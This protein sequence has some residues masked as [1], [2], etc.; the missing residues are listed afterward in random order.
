MSI[1]VL[2]IVAYLTFF[3]LFGLYLNRSNKSSSDWATGGGTMGI[4][5]LAAGV[6]GTRI[7]GAGTYGMA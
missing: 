4:W 2:V 3:T 5:M 7:G 1:S 6:A